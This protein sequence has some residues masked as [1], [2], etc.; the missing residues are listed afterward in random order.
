MPSQSTCL[1]RVRAC[2]RGPRSV[3]TAPAGR[4]RF[5][6]ALSFAWTP[7]STLPALSLPPVTRMIAQAAQTY[8]IIVRDRTGKGISFY[9]QDPPRYGGDNMYAGRHGIFGGRTPTQL[10]ADFPWSHLQ[11]L[12]MRLCSRAPCER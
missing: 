3:L 1:P 5:P 2:S 7:R 11:V 4:T 10:L 6:R 12:K 9:A 8:G